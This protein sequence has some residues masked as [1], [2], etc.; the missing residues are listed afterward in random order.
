M[1]AKILPNP[2]GWSDTAWATSSKIAS[3]MNGTFFSLW[4]VRTAVVVG[5]S[6][7]IRPPPDHAGI[8]PIRLWAA[9]DVMR[10]VVECRPMHVPQIEKDFGRHVF[11]PLLGTTLH[12]LD[13]RGRMSLP[14]PASF[15]SQNCVQRLSVQAK[16]TLGLS[17]RPQ[18]MR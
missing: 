8:F 9:D 3:G 11:S 13:Q 6:V 7:V 1:A 17:F 14:F 5:V 12:T 4:L 10:A 2:A 16:R 18:A 15:R